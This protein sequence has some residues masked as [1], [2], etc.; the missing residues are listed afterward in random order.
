MWLTV[1]ERLITEQFI[2]D[3]ELTFLQQ[4]EGTIIKG[5]GGF[6]YIEVADAI[7]ECKARGVFRKEK[8]SPLPG[9][10]VLFTVN[11]G[12]ENTID[13]ILP[14]RNVFIRPP[15]ANIDRLFVVTS[16]CEPKPNTLVIDKLIA[17]AEKNNVE[18][19]IVIT[20]NDLGDSTELVNIYKKAGFI[21]VVTS[22]ETGE[23]ADEI[24]NLIEGHVSA[25]A[26]NTGVGKSS[27]LNCIDSSL[28]L[29]TGEISDK[30]GRGRHTTRH[31]ELFKVCGGYIADTPGF[32][33]I[34]F[35]SVEKILKDELPFCFR[36][37]QDFL[38]TCK[39]STCSHTND[40]GC[41]II[42]AVKSG[43]IPSS[44]HDNYVAMYNEVKNLKEWEL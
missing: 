23:G 9:D 12:A 4:L 39:F 16:I 15:I 31:I 41:K 38:G 27:L 19:V 1:P 42:E 21:T 6:Y 34:D 28:S 25:F 13:K 43:V 14:R 11:D 44:R 17:V 2:L 26:G 7:Y 36:E 35:Q 8:I 32:S 24:K 3:L 33:S 20:K 10:R 29:Q 37:F 22:S 30:L 18:P 5:I 40:K